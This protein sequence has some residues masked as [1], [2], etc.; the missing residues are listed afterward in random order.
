[1]NGTRAAVR[2]ALDRA[3]RLPAYLPSTAL[4]PLALGALL[5]ATSTAAVLATANTPPTITNAT[6]TPTLLNEGQAATLTVAFT[7]PDAADL[8]TLRIKWFEYDGAPT[9]VVQVPAG[10]RSVQVSHTYVDGPLWSPRIQVTLYD[11]QSKPG[12]P[13][14]NNDGAGKDYVSVP[15][16]VN[17]V[18]PTIPHGSVTVKRLGK[19]QVVVEGDVVDPGA[20]DTMRVSATWYDPSSPAPMPCNPSKDGRHFKCEHTY[21]ASLPAGTYDIF[22]DA[23]DDD[24]GQ[25][26]Y[27]TSVQIP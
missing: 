11:R 15:V 16:Q 24:G 20:H 8:H 26:V 2:L 25:G 7:D 9:Q 4:R 19:R 13:N 23:R 3:R 17:N 6:V 18:A 14:D 1:M 10:Q 27:T 12:T 22:L 5:L 21:G